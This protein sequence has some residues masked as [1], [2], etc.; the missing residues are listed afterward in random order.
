[1]TCPVLVGCEESQVLTKAFRDKGIEAYSC[2]VQPTRGNPGW[3]FQADIFDVIPISRWSLI[4]LH[5]D[6]TAM[7]LSGNRWYG[8]GM[9]LHSK[10]KQAV[11][12]TI[13][14]WELALSYSDRVA[15]ENPASVIFP[16]LPGVQYIQPWQFGHGETKKTGFA[17]HGLP[18]L[19][20][21][22]IVEGREPRIWKMPPS[23]TRKRDRSATFPGIA[24]AI[25]DQWG[26]VI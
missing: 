13:A 6:C 24:A 4:V 16:H 25:A 8:Q 23:P 26:G 20:P 5:P 12:W 14:L 18:E 1:M 15:L 9:P 19:S 11:A 7:A 3:H 10:R 17:R 22:Q 2:D 21:T